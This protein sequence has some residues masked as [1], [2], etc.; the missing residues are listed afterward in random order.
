MNDPLSK[1]PHAS[2][3][4]VLQEQRW[5]DYKEKVIQSEMKDILREFNA[6]LCGAPLIPRLRIRI[7]NA[8]VI[9]ELTKLEYT[10]TQD[11]EEKDMWEISWE[12]TERKVENLNT[13]VDEEEEECTCLTQGPMGWEGDAPPPVHGPACTRKW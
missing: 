5:M 12:I 11:E 2:V 9:R 10:V 13:I 3:M 6:Y 1:I 7:Y 4:R 8:G